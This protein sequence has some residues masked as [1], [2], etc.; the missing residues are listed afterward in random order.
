[1]CKCTFISLL[2]F[3]E[4][5]NSMD[6]SYLYDD[7]DV[8]INKFNIK[9]EIQLRKKIKEV[10][11]IEAMKLV[12]SSDISEFNF[13]DLCNIHKQLY[14]KVFEWAGQSRMTELVELEP[15]F[16][17]VLKGTL[18]QYE[19]YLTVEKSSNRILN[20]MK[21][22]DWESLNIYE[23]VSEIAGSFAQLWGVHPFR[24]GNL[25]SLTIFITK[26]AESKGIMVSLDHLLE[27]SKYLR[28]ALVDASVSY[29][30][31]EGFRGSNFLNEILLDS[32]Q[33]SKQVEKNIIEKVSGVL[34]S[35]DDYKKMI[36]VEKNY[37][38]VCKNNHE[39]DQNKNNE[40]N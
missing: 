19:S 20:E 24:T 25:E 23:K 11:Y 39:V 27:N 8:L 30:S 4:R 12:I 36:S 17:G 5:G 35:L 3:F 40:R 14:H 16:D 1:M 38:Q 6:R 21:A 9:N 10:I 7:C 33:R 34:N 28:A 26:F 37:S 31:I 22:M 13:S 15:A 18:I 29:N 2:D 32:I